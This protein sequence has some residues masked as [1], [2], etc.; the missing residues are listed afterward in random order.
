MPFL[1]VKTVSQGDSITQP[2]KTHYVVCNYYL[3]FVANREGHPPIG[4]FGV[5][6][7][8]QWYH[9]CLSLDRPAIG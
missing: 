9:S 4:V 7:E 2:A 5:L 3:Q 1:G 6:R 8:Y